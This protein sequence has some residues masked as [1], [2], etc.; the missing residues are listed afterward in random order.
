M[1]HMAHLLGASAGVRKWHAVP[2]EKITLQQQCD[3]YVV[4]TKCETTDIEVR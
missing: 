3:A 1:G 2:S 4:E